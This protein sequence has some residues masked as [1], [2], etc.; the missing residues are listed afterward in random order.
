MK[1]LG[2][3]LLLAVAFIVVLGGL[4]FA[5]IRYVP[6]VQDQFVA[7]MIGSRLSAPRAELVADDALRVAICG[8]GSPM[9]NPE[10]APACNLVMAAGKIFVVDV[11]PGSWENAG[12]WRLPLDRVAAVFFTHFHSDH[13]GDL[14]EV[15]LQSWVGDRPQPLLVYG[16]PGIE[17]VVNGYNEAFAPDRSHRVAHHGA[18]FL[19]PELGIMQARLLANTDGTAFTGEQGT[20]VYD[21]DGLKITA[22]AVDHQ[23]ISPAYGYRFDYKGRA[24]VFSGDTHKSEGLALHSKGADVLVHEAMLMDVVAKMEAATAATGQKRFEKILH[25]IPDYHASPRDA[26][27]TA[28]AAGV[29]HLVMSHLIPPIP[30]WLGEPIFLR[31]AALDGVE[32]HVAFDGMLIEMPAGSRDVRFSSMGE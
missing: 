17:R 12:A 31:Q 24:V 5:A 21:Q 32:A 30:A 11:G 1:F 14:G 9:P 13:I 15:N 23:P 10:R 8:S 2:R 18:D 29:P 6:W 16:G 19:K 22:F 28:L 4:A 25:D 27:E 26:A 20:V 3:A 7:S